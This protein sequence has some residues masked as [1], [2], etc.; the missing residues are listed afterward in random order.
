MKALILAGGYGKRLR[1]LTETR[2]KP[3][4]EVAGKP[5]IVWQIEWLKKQGID[6]I[7]LAVG[8]LKDK[9]INE[10]GSGK[11]FGVRVSYVVEDEPMGTAGGLKNAEHIL[12]NEEFFFVLNGDILTNIE[13]DRLAAQLKAHPEIVGTIAVVPLPCPYGIVKFDE[14]CYAVHF[15]EKPTIKEYWI[16]AGVYCLRPKIFEY[17]P[18]RG[19]IEKETFPALAEKKMLMVTPCEGV[20]WKSIDTHKDIEEAERMLKSLKILA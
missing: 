13:L 3:L 16:N 12:K 14:R 20:F 11:R 6:E 17:L 19:D 15:M 5:I 1:P 4:V 9:I 10:I 18:E 7:V 8:Y 2:P